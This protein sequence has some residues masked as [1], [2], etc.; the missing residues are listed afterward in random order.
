M[1]SVAHSPLPPP[2]LSFVRSLTLRF[3]HLCFRFLSRSAAPLAIRSSCSHRKTSHVVRTT[4]AVG[5][6]EGGPWPTRVRPAEL[7]GRLQRSVLR[8]AARA[9][10]I[11]AALRQGARTEESGRTSGAGRLLSCIAA[12]LTHASNRPP[13]CLP[14]FFFPGVLACLD[15]YMNIV[16]EQTEEHS[17]TS[18]AVT[19]YGECFIR[20]NNVLYISSK[21][22]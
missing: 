14:V 1:I 13:S 21:K 22:V 10:A 15:G 4:H 5:L 20:G 8:A 11:C 19:S 7:W 6:P 3:S 18:G 12:C 9:R 16:M 2:F 17:A